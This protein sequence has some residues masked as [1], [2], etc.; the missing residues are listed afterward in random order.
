MKTTYEF[1]YKKRISFDDFDDF[2]YEVERDNVINALASI[3]ADNYV[4]NNPNVSKSEADKVITWLF[5]DMIST[6]ED[7]FVNID[8]LV[9][10]YNDELTK[11]FEDDAISQMY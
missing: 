2:Y 3:M 8:S 11:Y 10:Y 5:Q 9:E 7:D 6:A 1:K 4:Y